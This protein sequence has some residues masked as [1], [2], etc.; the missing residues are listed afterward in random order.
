MS[1]VIQAPEKRGWRP[2]YLSP[3]MPGSRSVSSPISRAPP[4][5]RGDASSTSQLPGSQATGM[6]QTLSKACMNDAITSR[7]RTLLAATPDSS[8]TPPP[9]TFLQQKRI[10]V[11]DAAAVIAWSTCAYDPKHAAART[12]GHPSVVHTQF[13]RKLVLHPSAAHRRRARHCW[14]P[15]HNAPG[16]A[17]AR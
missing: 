13:A 10:D 1:F 5:H 15:A 4:P 8:E 14:N 11:R 17:P 16:R 12:C 7:R 3:N 2:A 9:A 6:Q